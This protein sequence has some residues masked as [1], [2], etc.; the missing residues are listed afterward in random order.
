MSGWT[1]ERIELLRKLWSDGL[2]ASQIA[3][4]LGD[5]SRNGVIGKVHRLGLPGRAKDMRLD[6]ATQRQRKTEA[7]RRRRQER[8][9]GSRKP[10]GILAVQPWPSQ[11][12]LL[13]SDLPAKPPEL[14]PKEEASMDRAVELR[15]SLGQLDNNPAQP[16]MCRWPYGNPARETVMY[17]GAK[18]VEGRPFCLGHYL[19]AYQPLSERRERRRAA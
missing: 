12:R 11:R 15:V 9:G 1:D 7:E 17:C 6:P 8:A 5:V 10:S 3:Y 14:S 13:T 16:S 18:T 4:E 2:S 19:M